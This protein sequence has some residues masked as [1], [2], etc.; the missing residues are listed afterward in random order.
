MIAFGQ[1][2]YSIPNNIS[3]TACEFSDEDIGQITKLFL[4]EF[5][6]ITFKKLKEYSSLI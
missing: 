1:L 5:I 4:D 2:V 3:E 6:L